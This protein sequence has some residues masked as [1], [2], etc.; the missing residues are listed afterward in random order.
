MSTH[1]NQEGPATKF[2]RRALFRLASS[3]MSSLFTG[4]VTLHADL[5]QLW[6]DIQCPSNVDIEPFWLTDIMWLPL[7]R[8]HEAAGRFASTPCFRDACRLSD[9]RRL[10]SEPL[11]HLRLGRAAPQNNHRGE[12][13]HARAHGDRHGDPIDKSLL[14]CLG[15][16][17]ALLTQISHPW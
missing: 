8:M 1:R 15:N 17:Q 6:M 14:C 2:D 7:N 3:A 4:V 10:L 5:H 12:E 13:Q 11:V 16:R 9:L